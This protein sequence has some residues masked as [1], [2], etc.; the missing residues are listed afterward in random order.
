M[1]FFLIVILFLHDLS[2]VEL[3]E[4]HKTTFFLLLIMEL[5]LEKRI[6]RKL[7][8]TASQTGFSVW[9]RVCLKNKKQ[10]SENELNLP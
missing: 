2:L 8:S 3:L 10:F 6:F 5:F 4:T 1:K 9:K 7:F